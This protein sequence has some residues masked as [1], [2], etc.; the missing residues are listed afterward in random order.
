M[1]RRAK[2]QAASLVRFFIIRLRLLLPAGVFGEIVEKKWV[3]VERQAR[4]GLAIGPAGAM[5]APGRHEHPIA[6][7]GS[8]EAG[9]LDQIIALAFQDEPELVMTDVEVAAIGGGRRGHAL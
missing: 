9:I 1:A 3:H 2:A 8:E 7:I 6:R 5:E 4:V